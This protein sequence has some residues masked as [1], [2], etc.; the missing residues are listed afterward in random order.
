MPLTLTIS[1]QHMEYREAMGIQIKILITST[2][3]YK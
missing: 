2:L 1:Y 3:V